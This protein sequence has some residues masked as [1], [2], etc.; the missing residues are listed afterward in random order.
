[1]PKLEAALDDFKAF[2]QAA[3]Q[4]SQGFKQLRVKL[5]QQ[6]GARDQWSLVDIRA[7]ADFLLS[8]ADLRKRSPWH[9]RAWLHWIGFCARPGKGH[10][11]DP[12]RQQQLVEIYRRGVH[13]GTEQAVWAEWWNMWRRVSAGLFAEIQQGLLEDVAYYLHPSNTRSRKRQAELAQRAYDD[14]VRLL[15]SLEELSVTQKQ[16]AGHWLMERLRKPGESPHTW[17]A[18]GRLGARMPFSASLDKVLPPDRVRPWLEELLKVDWRKQQV[19]ALAATLMSRKTGDRALD[20]DDELR[21]QVCAKLRQAKA[22]E[23]WIELVRDVVELDQ[24]DQG[25]LFGES[26]PVGLVLVG[27]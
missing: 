12:E 11:A 21:E 27:G 15:G 26:L 10:P 20:L 13:H 19:A 4:D 14:M 16:E 23:R 18:L 25:S 24:E 22:S 2:F 3:K 8:V 6:L 5:E 1:H 17:W 9:E 7:M